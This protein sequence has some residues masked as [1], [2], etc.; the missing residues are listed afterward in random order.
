MVSSVVSSL[1]K[2]GFL[3]FVSKQKMARKSKSA[4]DILLPSQDPEQSGDFLYK[5]QEL[6]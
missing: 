6:L 4:R 2:R 1:E 3:L 5:L